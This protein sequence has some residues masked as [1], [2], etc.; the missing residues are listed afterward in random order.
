[1]S[2][3]AE[4]VDSLPPT[5]ADRPHVVYIAWRDDTPLYV[6]MTNDLDRRLRAHRVS[7]TSEWTTGHTHV[8]FVDVVNRA[9]AE[10]LERQVIL[11]LRP[12]NNRWR[13]KQRFLH[14]LRRI[15]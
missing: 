11:D 1:M 8:E 3:F 5:L 2:T 7:S 10:R 9:A 12:I 14:V 15:E 13:L 6:G 4:W